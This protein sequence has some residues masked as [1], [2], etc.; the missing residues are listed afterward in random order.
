MWLNNAMTFF[1]FYF[2]SLHKTCL[3]T[4]AG[5]LPPAL[6]PVQ[7]VSLATAK[8]RNLTSDC[9]CCISNRAIRLASAETSNLT[10]D[11]SCCISSRAE[12]QIH[13]HICNLTPGFLHSKS[14]NVAGKRTRMQPKA[15]SQLSDVTSTS[16]RASLS[17]ALRVGGIAKSAGARG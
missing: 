8:T 13:A 10:P 3:L 6:T 12:R 5:Y 4:S 2:F 17:T 15:S 7:T 11:C 14:G 16:E 9:S 1:V